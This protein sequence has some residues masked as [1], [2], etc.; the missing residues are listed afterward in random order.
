M[1]EETTI[2]RRLVE[3]G[4]VLVATSRVAK[5][6]KWG[7]YHRN[8]AFAQGA[9]IL[10]RTVMDLDPRKVS[11]ILTNHPVGPFGCEF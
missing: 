4:W 3:S 8:D 6:I 11:I 1:K 9:G 10:L 2:C 5:V 7:W